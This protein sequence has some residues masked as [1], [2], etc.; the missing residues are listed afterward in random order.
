MIEV[1]DIRYRYRGNQEVLDG[2]NFSLG[3]SCWMDRMFSG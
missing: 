3:N 2:V 1:K